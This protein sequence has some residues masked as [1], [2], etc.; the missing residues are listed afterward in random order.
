[1]SKK[2]A[3]GRYQVS[4]TIN[5][6]RKFFYGTTKKAATEKMAAYINEVSFAPNYDD[7]ITLQQWINYWYKIKQGTITDATMQSY[8]SIIR[9]Y[10][11]PS[12]GGLKLVD[13]TAL[14]IRRLID[15]MIGLSSRT[16]SYTLTILSA[17]LKEAI[18]NGIIRKNPVAQIK[19]P[20][21]EKVRRMVTLTSS[22]IEEFIDELKNDEYK[23][24]F[25]VAFNTGLRRSELL[26]LTWADINFNKSTLKVSQTV[27]KNG[28]EVIISKTTKNEASKRTISIDNK[29]VQALHKQRILSDKRR[30]KSPSW[31]NNNLVFPNETGDPIYPDTIS[32]V[33]KKAAS[34]IGVPEF[35]MHGTRHTHAT[36]LIEAGVN[37][38]VIQ[39]RL[40]HASFQETMNTYSHITPIMEADVIDK[41]EQIF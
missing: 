33:C 10:I 35:S 38:K 22:Q 15:S 29:T 4:K 2:R 36:L 3:D 8:V 41:I 24:L 26:G 11:L 19:R 7:A 14:T 20:K 27:I 30:I 34:K 39:M 17:I 40:G 6:K 5:G 9:R 23:T 21:K 32:K 28:S 1:M 12:L 31:I 25:R 37:F 18:S 13:I 16:I